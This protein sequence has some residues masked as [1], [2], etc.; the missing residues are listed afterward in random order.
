MMTQNQLFSVKDSIIVISGATGVLGASITKHLALEGAKVI[1]LGRN[2]EKIK[3]LI[4]A[5][6]ETPHQ[7]FS[8]VA[9]VTK[10][11]ELDKARIILEESFKKIDVLINLAGG[12]MPGA[13]ITPEQ[14][15]LDAKVSELQ[16]VM[17][18]NY[19]GTFLPTKAFLPLFLKDLKG[20]IINISSM[21]AQRPISRVLG[22]GSAKA[23]IDNLTQWLAV[24]FCSKYGA[25][26]RV[27][28]IAPG[29]FLTEQNRKL[30][31]EE[32]GSLTSRGNQII[33]NTPMKRF[34]EPDELLGTVQ[35]LS[36]NA[37][38]FVTGIIVAVDG[39]FNSYSGV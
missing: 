23:A 12:N 22:Y 14:T 26:L 39:G 10:E 21:A 1:V 15:L 16:K 33:N 17:E 19:M 3:Q 9:D 35:W 8:L 5:I 7:I 37:S 20:S 31:T 36:S 25:D 27:N 29:F 28:A 38:K 11:D 30:L 2:K 32:D 4:T 6:G 24:E 18:L 13:V 34:G